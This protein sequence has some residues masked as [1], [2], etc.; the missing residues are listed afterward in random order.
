MKLRHGALG[1]L[2]LGIAAGGACSSAEE[3]L[4]EGEACSADAECASGLACLDGA[5]RPDPCASCTADEI[6]TDEHVCVPQLAGCDEACAGGTFCS[7]VGE[8]IPDGTCK[9]DADCGTGL[10]CDEDQAI[11]VPGG[12]CGA[13]EFQLEK[14]PPNML[15]VLD[16]SGSMDSDV[17]NSGGK[18]RWQVASEA[19]AQLLVDYDAT[20]SFGL[21]LFSACTGNGCAPGTIVLP[22]GSTAAAI[23][24]EIAATQLCN[25]GDP[26]TVIGGSLQVLLGEQSLQAAGRDNAI[27]LITDGQDNCGGGGAQAAAALL[28][29]PVPVTT[30]VVGFSGDV[31]AGELD[32]IAQAAGTAP[33]YQADDAMQLSAALSSIAASVASCTYTLD[34]APDGAIYVFFNDD[35]QQIPQSSS[36]GWTYD[37]ATNTITF[38]GAACDQIQDGTVT[39]IDIVFGCAAPTPE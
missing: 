33:Y 6:C 35:P 37:P 26:E 9:D 25:S 8:C 17:P 13:N 3:G 2:W 10:V 7:A 21:D 15:I 1:L 27:L 36:D 22:I 34:S 4:A 23:N 38:H 11:C 24:Q 30:Y 19:I 39:D 18:S 32:A 20:V 5:C 12:D 28:A 16:R 14:L 29:Q 31:N